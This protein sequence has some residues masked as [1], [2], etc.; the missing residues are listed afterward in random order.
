MAN[1]NNFVRSRSVFTPPM[2]CTAIRFPSEAVPA[3]KAAPRQTITSI[4]HTTLRARRGPG[5]T[6]QPRR[7]RGPMRRL[8]IC[9]DLRRGQ[10][11]LVY[12]QEKIKFVDRYNWEIRLAQIQLAQW[13]I[14]PIYRRDPPGLAHPRA[15]R[16]ASRGPGLPFPTGASSAE[17][18]PPFSLRAGSRCASPLR[19]A[20]SRAPGQSPSTRRTSRRASAPA[21]AA[22]SLPLEPTGAAAVATSRKYCQPPAACP[23][24]PPGL[25]QGLRPEDAHVL[26]HH[27]QPPGRAHRDGP[28]RELPHHQAAGARGDGAP[29]ARRRA[30]PG[31][32]GPHALSRPHA[33]APVSARR[34]WRTWRWP[35]SSRTS[36]R[37]SPAGSRSE[38]RAPPPDPAARPSRR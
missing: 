38:P 33:P 7:L 16:G 37:T 24:P 15:R 5:D 2:R 34:R 19:R 25:P 12:P 35:R 1:P 11:L 9:S 18:P 29:P 27:R 32:D 22:S 10:V 30:R 23:P 21:P 4:L 20:S 13:F 26:P 36:S 3:E 31:S 6:V 17:P 28:R 14:V 8:T